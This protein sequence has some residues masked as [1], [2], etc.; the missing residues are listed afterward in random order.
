V[1]H[2][3]CCHCRNAPPTIS[4]CSHPLFGLH[5]HS[6]SVDECQWVPYFLHGGIQW[7]LCFICASMS[8]A[9]WSDS[10]AAAICHMATRVMEY[11][12]EGSTSAAVP[13]RS[14]SDNIMDWYNT[15]GAIT[16]GTALV[17]KKSNYQRSERQY[18]VL[19]FYA[20][21][22]EEFLLVGSTCQVK[23]PL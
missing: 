4:L 20:R 12:W 9:I 10:S 22:Q 14:T 1:T 2:C 8:D 21:V 11:W 6:A 5:K 19:N 23:F 17:H 13:P 16:F 18:F 15:I 7:H 3:H